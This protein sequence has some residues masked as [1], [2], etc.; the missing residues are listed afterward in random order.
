MFI[1]KKEENMINDNH[2]AVNTIKLFLNNQI[3]IKHKKES[4]FSRIKYLLIP[5][6]WISFISYTLQS[7]WQSK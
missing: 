3:F 6:Q 7:F 2:F 4:I 1:T 5:A